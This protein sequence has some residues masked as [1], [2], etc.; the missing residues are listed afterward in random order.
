[1]RFHDVQHQPRAISL[2]RRSL[3]SGRV[4]HAYL[5]DGPE[6]VGRELTATALAARLLCEADGLAADA[7]A[8]GKC[9]S[10]ELVRSGNHADLHLIHRGLHKVHPERSVRASRGLFLGV[11]LIRHFVIDRA[12]VAPSL[13]RRRVFIVR[14]AERMNDEAQNALLKT[15]EEPPASACL[16]LITTAAGR[17]LSTVRS[18]S[19]RVAFDFLPTAFVQERLATAGV[20]VSAARALARLSGGSL[21]VAR[22]WAAWKVLDLVGPLRGLLEPAAVADPEAS[23]RRMLELAETVVAAGKAGEELDEQGAG[24]ESDESSGREEKERG[25]PAAGTTSELREAVRL[26]L[27]VMGAIVRDRLLARCGAV[28]SLRTFAGETRGDVLARYS[29]DELAACVQAVTRAETLLE[30]NVAP[31]LALENLMV[32]FSAPASVPITA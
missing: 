4:P 17:L 7:D 29:A 30:R 25:E 2:L 24:D 11:D 3:R 27:A 1:M 26:I 28:E 16:I 10:C 6:G 9:R 20:E 13:G 32:R 31:Q 22:R 15:L 19:Q 23:A 18:R 12:W 8:C 5:F 14:E 21:G